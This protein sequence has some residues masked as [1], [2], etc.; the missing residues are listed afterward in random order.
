MKCL[1]KTNYSK[2][3]SIDIKE[4]HI[5]IHSDITGLVFKNFSVKKLWEIIFHS[6]GFNKTYI[7]PTFTFC[8]NK[9]KI[10]D[11]Y[12]TKSE[13]G[14]LSEYFRTHVATKR[15]IHPLHSVAIYSKNSSKKLKHLSHSSFGKDSIWEWFSTSKNVCNVALGLNLDGGATFCHFAEEFLKVNYRQYVN[16]PGK[17][18]EKRKKLI[19]KKYIYFIKKKN[20]KIIN[21]WAKCEKDLRKNKLIET[22]YV[23][24]NRYKIL[25]MN[26]FQVTKF[27]IKKLKKN[28]R[29]L[30]E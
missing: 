19:K 5:I 13:T 24:K 3:S 21:N 16:L 7:F 20:K 23:G 9:K 12:K 11:Y 29:Y 2:L 17:V 18:Y 28:P 26:T 27:L 14:I 10:W 4:K 25:K 6:F 30:V 8:F 15:T 22:Y 1:L